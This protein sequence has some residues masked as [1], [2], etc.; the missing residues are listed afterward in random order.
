MMSR[1]RYLYS[2]QAAQLR[3]SEFKKPYMSDEGF[4]SMEDNMDEVELLQFQPWEISIDVETPPGEVGLSNVTGGMCWVLCS[5]T[6]NRVT[7]DEDNDCDSVTVCFQGSYGAD[8]SEAREDGSEIPLAEQNVWYA[9]PSSS[10]SGFASRNV[11]VVDTNH[12]GAIERV[13]GGLF[14]GVATPQCFKFS[15]VESGLTIKAK[16]KQDIQA[17][18][19]QSPVPCEW[20]AILENPCEPCQVEWDWDNSDETISAGT[21]EPCV[22]GEATIVVT[23]G[24]GAYSWSL[25]SP[26]VGGSGFSLANATTS[27][28]VNTIL[29][30]C[31][32]CGSAIVTV[33]S[34]GTETT[35]EVRCPDNGKWVAWETSAYHPTPDEVVPPV[36]NTVPLDCDIWHDDVTATGLATFGG[37]AYKEQVQVWHHHSTDGCRPDPC[38]GCDY[39]QSGALSN[40]DWYDWKVFD[41]SGMEDGINC[42][43]HLA[44]EVWHIGCMIIDR[45]Y[46]CQWRCSGTNC[47]FTPA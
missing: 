11:Y 27:V 6:I 21:G 28:P 10:D 7:W 39:C 31:S 32:A 29:A 33:T 37:A 45:R 26:G 17:W 18:C 43:H 22:D 41:T 5:I 24:D 12:K 9:G 1:Q 14:F 2:P 13:E 40:P 4:R 25:A 30:D 34:C 16:F 8:S 23:G 47:S 15:G 3:H 46:S 20:D 36:Q 44:G 35:G 19:D 42:C 38:L